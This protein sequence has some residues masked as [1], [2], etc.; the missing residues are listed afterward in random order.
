MSHKELI[1]AQK[2]FFR[3]VEEF[4]ER[5]TGQKA[6]E[7]A[8]PENFGERIHRNAHTLAPR[9]VDAVAFAHRAFPEF[10]TKQREGSFAKAKT[11]GGLKVVIG[12]QSRNW[13]GWATCR[14]SRSRSSD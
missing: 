14:L 13:S 10:Y 5:A 4:F 1:Q 9:A 3:I 11:I 6:T 2:G 12:G 8:T 7:F